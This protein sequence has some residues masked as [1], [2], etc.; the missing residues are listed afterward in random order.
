MAIVKTNAIPIKISEYS[1]T[2]IIASFLTRNFGLVRAIFKGARRKAKAYEC[3]MDLLLPGE[4]VFYARNSGL[5]IIKEYA[6]KKTHTALRYNL[7]R[8]RSAMACLELIRVTAVE[9]EESRRLF[10]LFS[11]ALDACSE[12]E[13]PWSAAYSFIL[14]ALMEE[15]FLPA[16]QNCSICGKTEFPSPGKARTALSFT[17][18]GV[19]CINCGKGSRVEGWLSGTALDTLKRFLTLSPIKASSLKL[20]PQTNIEIRGFLKR[21]CEFAFELRLRMLN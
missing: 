6:P 10:D 19:L 2:S 12:G 9:G 16:L 4:L 21:W 3:S 13:H 1:E 11:N 8:Y 20:D 14:S 7:D 17:N 18:G 15:G 5:N